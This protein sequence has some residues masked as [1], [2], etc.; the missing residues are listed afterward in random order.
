[1]IYFDLPMRTQLVGEIERLLAPGAPLLIG[2]A[3]TLSGIRTG[4]HAQGPSVY[5]RAAGEPS[6]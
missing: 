3:E 2:H 4:L 6:P 1:M 5:R